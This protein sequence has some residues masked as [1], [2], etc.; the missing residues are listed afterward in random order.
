MQEK[1][2]RS[3]V[4]QGREELVALAN[5]VTNIVLFFHSVFYNPISAILTKKYTQLSL[6]S[7]QYF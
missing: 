1:V 7:Q 3:P 4:A 2:N 5:T 6:D